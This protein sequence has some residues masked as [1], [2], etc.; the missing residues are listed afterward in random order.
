MLGAK[1]ALSDRWLLSGSIE[2]KDEFFFSERHDER[3]DAYEMLNLELKYQAENWSMAVYGKNVTD[4]LVKT[5]G[6]GSFGNDPRNFYETEPY[7]Q[8]AAPR[9]V[10]VKGEMSF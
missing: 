7:N 1:Y 10:G 9:V 5:R 6:F 3:S 4:E 2:A 8:F